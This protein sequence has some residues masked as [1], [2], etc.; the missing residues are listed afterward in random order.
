MGNCMGKGRGAASGVLVPSN[1][2]REV[3]A[4][5]GPLSRL[6]P[7]LLRRIGEE[8]PLDSLAHFAATNK[9]ANR[10]ASHL[11]RKA[12]EVHHKVGQYEPSVDGGAR[13]FRTHCAEIA[14]LPKNHQIKPLQRL[15]R[16]VE[17]LPTPTDVLGAFRT[18]AILG[19]GMSPEHKAELGAA[20]TKKRR[21]LYHE[22]M[23]GLQILALHNVGL[24]PEQDDWVEPKVHWRPNT[25][26]PEERLAELELAINETE[27]WL[28][29]DRRLAADGLVDYLGDLPEHDRLPAYRLLVDTVAGLPPTEAMAGLNELHK[30]LRRLPA[31]DVHEALTLLMS[32]QP[33][34]ESERLDYLLGVAHSGGRAMVGGALAVFHAIDVRE[35]PFLPESKVILLK[36]MTES[37]ARLPEPNVL[38]GLRMAVEQCAGLPPEGKLAM[39]P[40]LLKEWKRTRYF[41]QLPGFQLIQSM[42][43]DMP[44]EGQEALLKILIDEYRGLPSQEQR[45]AFTGILADIRKLPP[46]LKAGMLDL[47]VTVFNP[48]S[49][50]FGP[51]MLEEIQV[52]GKD[53][54]PRDETALLEKVAGKLRH[55][56]EH[57]GVRCVRL[58]CYQSRRLVEELRTGVLVAL[59]ENIQFMPLEARRDGATSIKRMIPALPPVWGEEVMNALPEDLRSQPRR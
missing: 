7:E 8:L 31:A 23:N 22:R 2:A 42:G 50:V 54:N 1:T 3:A 5:Q 24:I 51:E 10:A 27:P 15:M 33:N 53:L 12:R 56:P 37:I 46:A 49:H 44:P 13:V 35:M 57:S 29:Q 55:L 20:L 34:A 16:N 4:E 58:V 41:D 19:A 38:E 40:T 17:W 59:A 32:H 11:L 21:F 45:K 47:F 36:A 14:R 39:A 25:L 18:A 52:A 6:P 26:P 43:K 28:P 30:H 9:E 48:E